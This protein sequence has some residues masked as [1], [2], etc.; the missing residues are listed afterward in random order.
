MTD[1]AERGSGERPAKRPRTSTACDACRKRRAKCDGEKPKCT[2]CK[3]M[4]LECLYAFDADK[5]KP[6]TKDIVNAL[7][8]RIVA[9]EKELA[10]VKA[11]KG[12]DDAVPLNRPHTSATLASDRPAVTDSFCGG[13][14]LNSYGELRFYGPTSSYRAILGEATEGSVEAAR[15]WSLT[16]APIPYAPPL[17]PYLPRKPPV[18]SADLSNRLI[19][20][21]FEYCFSQFGLVDER[22]FLA[23]L[24][25]SASQRTANYS[26]LLLH[27]V[28]AVGCRYLDPEDRDFKQELCGDMEDPSTRGDVFINWARMMLDQEW[29]HPDFSTIR[30]LTTLSVYLAG[31]AMDG[32]ALMFASQ[33]MRLCEDFGLHLD[34]HRLRIGSGGIPQHLRDLRCGAFYSAFFMDTLQCTYLGRRPLL[35]VADLDLDVPQVDSDIEYDSP[36]Y[37]SSSFHAASKL[38]RIMSRLLDTV[39]SL[40]AGISLATRQAAVPE[41]HLALETWYLELPSPLRASTP[42][43]SKAPHPH[44]LGLNALYHA[45]VIQLHRPF[46]RRTSD[47]S[48]MGVSTEKCLSSAKHIE[49][50]PLPQEN[51]QSA[52]ADL[53][54][55]TQV[56]LV[57]LQREAYGLRFVHPLFQYCCFTSGTILALSATE[58]NI[59]G[60]PTRDAERKLQADIDLK[61]V[62]SALREV[63]QTWKTALTSANV[64]ETFIQSW[65]AGQAQAAAHVLPSGVSLPIEPALAPEPPAPHPPVYPPLQIPEA[66][67]TRSPS[68]GAFDA[69]S[70]GLF[71]DFTAGL[72][73]GSFEHIFPLW[74]LETGGSSLDDFM[75]LLHP[76]PDAASEAFDLDPLLLV[77]SGGDTALQ[78]EAGGLSDMN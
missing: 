33:A 26:P 13:L 70:G 77:G 62:I 5:R 22:A 35:S 4:K 16:R 58:N 41:L 66:D 36:S 76:T 21:A 65:G 54:S 27:I 40:K 43:P 30:S 44:I 55:G 63:G 56:R 68:P 18:L 19:G 1:S 14:A 25:K 6:V 9:L 42:T 71:S 32:P 59:S 3:S 45:T 49:S 12:I 8:M 53:A 17:D 50:C 72:T 61:D 69:G 74:D 29:L 7:T 73:A 47:G 34:I 10:E 31:Q 52:M 78:A 15:A 48:E 38:V 46:F 60:V 67:V 37:R 28:L 24:S 39:Y 2:R 23:D 57:K 64:L 51:S 75:G 11:Q 20:L